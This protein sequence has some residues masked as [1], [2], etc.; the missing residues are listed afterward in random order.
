MPTQKYFID[1]NIAGVRLVQAPVTYANNYTVEV[2]INWNINKIG[3]E[4][5]LLFG[6]I[7]DVETSTYLFMVNPENGTYRVMTGSVS[8]NDWD[9]VSPQN[10]SACI[11]NFP[12][13]LIYSGSSV[14]N[15]AIS[16]N[17]DTFSLYVNGSPNPLSPGLF[18]GSCRG[19]VGIFAQSLN[20]SPKAQAFFDNF[21]VSCPPSLMSTNSLFS[22]YEYINRQSSSDFVDAPVIE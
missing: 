19:M 14:N 11:H 2:D 3:F 18:N 20:G 16:C 12:P 4:Y 6:Q 17:K 22:Q 8:T 21:K 1:R 15:L 9:C 5:G 7:G 13:G 10:N